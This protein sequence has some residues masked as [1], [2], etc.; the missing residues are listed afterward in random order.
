MYFICVHCFGMLLMFFNIFLM[1][2]KCFL[3]IVAWCMS[4]NERRLQMR[5]SFDW[6]SFLWLPKSTTENFAPSE[7]W[8]D[9]ILTRSQ[10]D[11]SRD[12][13]FYACRNNAEGSPVIRIPIANLHMLYLDMKTCCDDCR[14]DVGPARC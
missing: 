10:P 12:M 13:P 3:P 6:V 2:L 7:K 5:I 8:R 4:D 14:S 11:H 9:S 1:R